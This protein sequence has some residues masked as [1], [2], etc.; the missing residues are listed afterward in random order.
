MKS[1]DG[2]PVSSEFHLRFG[3]ELG[4]MISGAYDKLL[5][6]SEPALHQVQKYFMQSDGT[7]VL[8]VRLLP[9]CSILKL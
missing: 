4:L 9:D 6:L 1:L 5:A 7:K 3:A 8:N 2:R